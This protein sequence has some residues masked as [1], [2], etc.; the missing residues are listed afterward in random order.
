MVFLELERQCG[1]SHE[2]RRRAQGASCWAPG[3]S[4]LHARGKGV[5]A[6]ALKSWEGNRSWRRTE[7]VFLRSFSC[8]G[9]KPGVPLTCAGEIREL[10][11]VPLRS[12][13]YCGFGRGLSGLHWVWCN[14]G[15]TRLE[16]MQEPQGSSPFLTP[17]AGS[18][19]SWDRRGRPRFVLRHGTPFAARFVQG[20]TGHLSSC[21]W[22]LWVFP[23]DAWGCQWPFMLRLQPQGCILR[24]VRARVVIKGGEGHRGPSE[25]GTT[26]EA[27]S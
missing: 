19:Q 18:L 22:N 9:R 11:R 3:K 21:I 2:V 26:H 15:G 1:V 27:T 7:E 23:D 16:L 14:G 25:C 17:K 24:G 8:C 20:V 6:I 13:G 4:G 12:Q 10:L 5:R